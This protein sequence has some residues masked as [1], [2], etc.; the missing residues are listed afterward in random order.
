MYC[1]G[2]FSRIS[3]RK[4]HLLLIDAFNNI[5]QDGIDAVLLIAG[6]KVKSN[7]IYYETLK[8]R[9][10]QYNAKGNIIRIYC[11]LEDHEDQK[12][13]IIDALKIF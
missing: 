9:I 5:I 13:D 3:P 12:K 6:D 11:G 4:G 1:I 2:I 10:N 7:E 8:K